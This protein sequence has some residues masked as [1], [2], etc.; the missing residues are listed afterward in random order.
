MPLDPI[1]MVQIFHR[2]RYVDEIILA[3]RSDL[4]AHDTIPI[5]W[6]EHGG[7]GV[8]TTTAPSPVIPELVL[9]RVI[10]EYDRCYVTL[11]TWQ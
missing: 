2:K 6:S 5:L 9:R 8:C 3:I 11:R 1:S 7:S 4:M 10:R